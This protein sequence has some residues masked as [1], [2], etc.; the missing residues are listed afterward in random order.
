MQYVPYILSFASLL[1]SVYIFLSSN[2]KSN[3]TELT[4]VIVK[5]E[6]I[7]SGIRDIK[8][9]IA[10]IKDDQRDDHDR[11]IRNEESVKAAWKQINELR[12][13]INNE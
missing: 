5:L 13:V 9:E 10:S 12:G 1:L 3:T 4:T 2:N 11:L 6:N 7:S 8:T